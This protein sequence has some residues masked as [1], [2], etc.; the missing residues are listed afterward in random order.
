MFRRRIGT[1]RT[2]LE[3]E[4]LLKSMDDL[5]NS[6]TGTPRP[7]M[8]SLWSGAQLFPLVNVRGLGHSLVI[9]A[10]LPGIKPD[11][12]EIKIDGGILTLRGERKPQD[13]S[14]GVRY[15]RRERTAGTFLRSLALPDK[16]DVE[17]VGAAYKHGVL[18]ITLQKTKATLS[19]QIAEKGE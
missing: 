8:G 15:H 6:A 17:H 11:E 13:V 12:L 3:L 18:T 5:F 4:R 14:D 19:R 2:W 7:W 10:E 1:D 9:T 16:V